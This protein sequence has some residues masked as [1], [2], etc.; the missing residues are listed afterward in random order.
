MAEHRRDDGDGPSTASILGRLG[1]ALAITAA[2]LWV[3]LGGPV[4]GRHMVGIAFGLA[5]TGVVC[6]RAVV[7]VVERMT[8]ARR[9]A[10]L[11]M[12]QA[13][14]ALRRELSTGAAGLEST[15]ILREKIGL[16]RFG[17]PEPPDLNPGGFQRFVSAVEQERRERDTGEIPAVVDPYPAELEH[18]QDM[19]RIVVCPPVGYGL[20]QE[21]N[22]LVM[23]SSA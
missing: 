5:L 17:A 6:A 11:A 14:L 22:L 4:D 3:V 18:G 8:I 23:S 2:D 19:R 13:R 1:A 10:R 16:P 9:R 20:R 12:V 15:N 7:D 21:S